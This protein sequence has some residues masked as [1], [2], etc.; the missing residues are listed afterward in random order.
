MTSFAP[1]RKPR[2]IRFVALTLAAIGAV[3]LA[4][5]RNRSLPRDPIGRVTDDASSSPRD[6]RGI[7]IT[8]HE[9]GPVHE[10]SGMA[11]F[12]DLHSG[13]VGVTA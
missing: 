6:C 7:G 10:G 12:M 11:T 8:G 5:S 2:S 4:A 9:L 1:W 3:T 13:F